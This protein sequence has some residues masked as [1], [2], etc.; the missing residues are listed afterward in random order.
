MPLRIA[1][2]A[3]EQEAGDLPADLDP[4]LLLLSLL[5]ASLYPL[6][7]PEVCELMTGQRPDD[8]TF[9]RRFAGHLEKLAAHLA[10]SPRT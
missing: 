1:W 3:A 8:D 2:V 10:R 7:L 9:A 5:G 6:L 4:E